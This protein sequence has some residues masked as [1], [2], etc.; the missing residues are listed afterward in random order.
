MPRK[1]EQDYIS[2]YP[3]PSKHVRFDCMSLAIKG[4]AI[5][6]EPDRTSILMVHGVCM[7]RV[8]NQPSRRAGV[9]E[10]LLEA[11]SCRCKHRLA[12]H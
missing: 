10:I 7:V 9:L 8:E 6:V 3:S 5:E 1:H 11:D 12:L 2:P 4:F